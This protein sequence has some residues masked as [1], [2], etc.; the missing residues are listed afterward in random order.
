MEKQN[1]S[2][3]GAAGAISAL[4]PASGSDVRLILEANVRATQMA[5]AHN[6]RTLAI[7]MRAA[8]TLR[9]GVQALAE[10]Q[11]DWIKAFATA[12]G[13]FRNAPPQLPAPAE[14]SRSSRD[15]DDSDEDFEDDEEEGEAAPDGS[16]TLLAIM[17]AI[18]QIVAAITAIM[19]KKSDADADPKP[20]AARDSK[21]EVAD[22]ADWRRAHEKG[23]A[24]RAKAAR[25]RAAEEPPTASTAASRVKP[26][27]GQVEVTAATGPIEN[28][29]T[30]SP[31]AETENGSGRARTRTRNRASVGEIIAMVPP[32]LLPKLMAAREQLTPNEQSW[33]MAVLGHMPVEDRRT[34][35]A[36]LGKMSVDE[37]VAM[38]RG[39]YA[40][41]SAKPAASSG[42]E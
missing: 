23:K 20:A 39:E 33:M 13:L 25:V 1:G 22:L 37:I 29:S 10:A 14:P 8:E 24:A 40:R 28:G 41:R 9:E 42:E 15:E 32:E 5:F 6:E 16:A 19:T 7:G 31:D 21:F 35:V 26:F 12:R 38:T 4:L 36:E 2:S 30:P 34:A 18:Q 27:S 3:P 17:P 11:A